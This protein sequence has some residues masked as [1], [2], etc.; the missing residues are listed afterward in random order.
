MCPYC[1]G[2][3]LE[4]LQLKQLLYVLVSMILKSIFFEIRITVAYC[5]H[6]VTLTVSAGQNFRVYTCFSDFSEHR[7]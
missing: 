5:L 6:A 3:Q 1:M 4:E 2:Q 7:P